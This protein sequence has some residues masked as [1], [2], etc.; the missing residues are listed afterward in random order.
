LLKTKQQEGSSFIA[1]CMTAYVL[2]YHYMDN[3]V[4]N[5]HILVKKEVDN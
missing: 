4:I 1:K 2:C 3:Q 5:V